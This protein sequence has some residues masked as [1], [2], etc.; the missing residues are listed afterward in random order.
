M[1]A[2]TVLGTVPATQE[3]L[4][5]CLTS[6]VFVYA[7]DICGGPGLGSGRRGAGQTGYRLALR[8]LTDQSVKRVLRGDRRAEEEVKRWGVVVCLGKHT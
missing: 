7:T 6:L 3:A 2:H 1:N 8:A 4:N 5:V